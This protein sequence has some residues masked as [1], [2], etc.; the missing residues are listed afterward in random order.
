MEA[1]AA[2]LS[3][4]AAQCPRRAS[5]DWARTQKPLQSLSLNTRSPARFVPPKSSRDHGRFSRHACRAQPKDKNS[6]GELGDFDL[7]KFVEAKVDSGVLSP[8]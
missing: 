6:A 8:S 3:S 2:S 5:L 4:P 1:F 7:A